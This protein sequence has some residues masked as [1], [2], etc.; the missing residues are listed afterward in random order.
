MSAPRR[1]IAAHAPELAAGSAAP[2][3]STLK[4]LVLNALLQRGQLRDDDPFPCPGDLRLEG[5]SFA[6]SH[7]PL[8]V[9]LTDSSTATERRD[10]MDSRLGKVCTNMKAQGMEIGMPT[11]LIDRTEECILLC[12]QSFLGRLVRFHPCSAG[13][14]QIRPEHAGNVGALRHIE[15][16]GR[17]HLA[18]QMCRQ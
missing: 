13:V 12:L 18:A 11:R 15:G 1:L 16:H 5:R 8:G 2:P 3:G 17:G 9:P 6:C 7:P 4:P 14:S 10:A